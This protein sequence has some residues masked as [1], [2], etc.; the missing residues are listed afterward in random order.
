MEAKSLLLFFL[1]RPRK[2]VLIYSK[3]IRAS[4]EAQ[5]FDEM[6]NEVMTLSI[7]LATEAGALDK[8]RLFNKA[9]E[10]LYHSKRKGKNQITYGISC[11]NAE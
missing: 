1:K 7:G 4:L 8:D 3:K 10:Y 6:N 11:L 2:N 5:K 9:D